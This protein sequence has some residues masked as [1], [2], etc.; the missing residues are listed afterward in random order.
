M[1]RRPRPKPVNVDPFRARVVRGPHADHVARWYWRAVRYLDGSEVVVWTGWAT[2]DEVARTLRAL[3]PETLP[4][5]SVARVALDTVDELLRAWIAA[6][7]DGVTR[8]KPLRPATLAAY[9][10]HAKRVVGQLGAMRLRVLDGATVSRYVADGRRAGDAPGTLTLDVTVLRMA[11][12]WSVR[13]GAAPSRDVD[14]PRCDPRE[15]VRPRYTPKASDVVA[16]LPHL[17]PWARDVVL[18]L[19]GTGA[20]I[21]EV[22]SLRVGA[23]ELDDGWI[24]LDGKTGPR[25]VPLSP[26][27]VDVLRPY[28]DGRAPS[29]RLWP[30]SSEVVRHLPTSLRRA[31]GAAGVPVWTSHALRRAAV[32]RLAR[33]GVDV[34]TAA[35]MLGHSPAVMLEV[36]RQVSADDL[37]GAVARAR[38]GALPGGRVL[39]FARSGGDPER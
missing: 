15:R 8:A 22:A 9:R 25:R 17:R 29:V 23:V 13:V 33:S 37:S 21:G 12:R 4:A 24:A 36:Y 38:L 14:W 5:A 35:A 3:P 10:Q 11:W 1:A 20:R 39:T 30:V 2:R 18:V 26:E 31:C 32:D 28:V 27:T 7:E 34:A 19:W 16:V 6:C